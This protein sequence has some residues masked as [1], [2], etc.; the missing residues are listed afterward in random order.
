MRTFLH[1]FNSLR[2]PIPW[3][4]IESL[5]LSVR[6]SMPAPTRSAAADSF[7]IGNL[8]SCRVRD[9]VRTASSLSTPACGAMNWIR[10]LIVRKG[11]PVARCQ[12]RWTGGSRF[13][14]PAVRRPCHSGW[15]RALRSPCEPRNPK[16]PHWS[17]H[18][19]RSAQLDRV[20]H[21]GQYCDVNLSV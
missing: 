19:G 10:S 3:K 11:C 18:H 4:P 1:V 21:A 2:I 9:R 14:P 16:Q 15:L 20:F 7:G 6:R 12:F 13:Y 17:V 5:Y 8:R